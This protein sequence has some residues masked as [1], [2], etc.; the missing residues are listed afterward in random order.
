MCRGSCEYN[1]RLPP[2][3]CLQSGSN[4]EIVLVS[5]LAAVPPEIRSKHVFNSVDFGDYLI[6]S[7]VQPM[8]DGRIEAYNDRDL[9]FGFNTINHVDPSVAHR[10]LDHYSIDWVILSPNWGMN[11]AIEHDPEWFD[12]Y[13]DGVAA[14]YVRKSVWDAYLSRKPE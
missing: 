13:E 1:T 14:V 2:A 12:L 6:F 7:D 3:G 11:I 10:I 4:E 5:A 8:F 9:L